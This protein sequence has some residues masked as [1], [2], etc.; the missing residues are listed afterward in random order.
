[1]HADPPPSATDWARF[2]PCA[3][4]GMTLMKAHFTSHAFERHSHETYS[5]GITQSGVQTFHCGGSLH[6]SLWGDII[7]FNPDEAHDGQRGTQEGFGYAMLYITREAMAQCLDREDGI[8]GATYFTQPL[9]RDRTLSQSL[10]QAIG[11]TGEAQE[12]LR[13]QELTRGALAALLRR[14]GERRAV[15]Q[16]AR[17]RPVPRAWRACGTTCAPISRRTSRS[18]R[19]RARPDCR[20]FTSLA[21]SAGS[22]VFRRMST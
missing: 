1:M 8:H 4:D 20:A 11:A 2:Q 13:A 10:A 18:R 5:I 6:A 19:W 16:G 3:I 14:H 21:P 9:V 15:P 17:S 7:L 22:L 12:S